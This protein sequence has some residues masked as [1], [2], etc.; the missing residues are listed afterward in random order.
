MSLDH[1]RPRAHGPATLS[2]LSEARLPS[3]FGDFRVV[4]FAGGGLDTEPLALVR[5][6]VKGRSDVLV[7]V[8]SE[9]L[10]G[11]VLGSLRCDCRD[12]LLASLDQIGRAPAG[13]LLY[14]RQE[15]R[16]IGLANKIRAYELQDRGHD[17]FEANRLLGFADD[18]RDY[19][20][21][22]RMLDSLGVES[23]RLLTNNPAKLEGLRR[24]GVRVTE[25]LPLVMDANPHNA[26]YLAAKQRRAGH[27]FGPGASHDREERVR[28]VA[29]AYRSR[30]EPARKESPC[31]R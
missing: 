6:D 9:C 31:P 10:T 23:V 14:L 8:H 22:A 19:A 20:L 2:R 28:H 26:E 18:A 25:R 13:V 17:T 21:A 1:P 27:L 30:P 12:Q 16:G 29:D 4:A 15:G 5:G 3:R 7:R 24:H 11:D